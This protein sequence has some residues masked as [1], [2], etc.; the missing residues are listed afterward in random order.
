MCNKFGTIHISNQPK[1]KEIWP[2]LPANV[3]KKTVDLI[4]IPNKSKCD[5]TIPSTPMGWHQCERSLNFTEHSWKQQFWKLSK[6]TL[7]QIST[8]EGTFTQKK[9]QEHMCNSIQDESFRGCS[10]MGGGKK[11]SLPKISQTYPIMMK[12]GTV[13]FY[14]KKIQKIYKPR[15]TPL[16]F[17]RQF[18]YFFLCL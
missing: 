10:Q 11:A 14:L 3:R 18:F 5:R 8:Y 6:N 12:L 17:C 15:D 1:N 2:H 9:L 7:T 4:K 13:I 16:E